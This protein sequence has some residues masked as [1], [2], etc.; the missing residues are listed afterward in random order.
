[1]KSTSYLL[2]APG[3]PRRE[4]LR[5]LSLSAAFFTVPGAFAEALSRKTASVEEGPFYPHQ[6]PLDTDNDLIIVNNS[7]TPAVGQVTHLTGR[8]LNA[9]GSPIRNATIEIWEVDGTGVYLADR[10][11][12]A[13]YDA[14]FQGFGRFLTGSTGEY[15]FRAIKPVAYPGRCA[16]HIHFK[17][18]RQ[19]QEAWNTQLFVKGERG[20]EQ[21]GI[22]RNIGSAQDR[23][24]VTVDFTPIKGSAAGELAA[25][26]DIVLG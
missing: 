16:P 23:A 15:Y 3:T 8:L 6:L 20:N 12:Q 19:G 25:R 7:I 24:S 11:H 22:Y 4:F 13:K 17:V 18:R 2:A 14:N 21:D 9:G 26:F 10:P 1:M 5:K